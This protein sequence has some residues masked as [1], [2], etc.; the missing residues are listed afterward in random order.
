M[1]DDGKTLVLFWSVVFF[2]ICLVQNLVVT[3]LLRH[4]RRA[5]NVNRRDRLRNDD[6]KEM[7]QAKLCWLQRKTENMVVW[8]SNCI[9]T[10]REEDQVTDESRISKNILQWHRFT[11]ASTAYLALEHKL[12]LSTVP[13]NKVWTST[14]S[15]ADC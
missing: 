5:I 1:L 15:K 9:R 8:S 7:V 12:Q 10:G 2:Y 14:E 13:H 11:I 3:A 6:I 4:L